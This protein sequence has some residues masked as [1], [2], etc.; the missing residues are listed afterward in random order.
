MCCLR[1]I[2]RSTRRAKC[3]S[4]VAL[5]ARLPFGQS[6]HVWVVIDLPIGAVVYGRHTFGRVSKRD[7]FIRQLAHWNEEP[8]E[9]R[10][11]LT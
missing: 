11:C 9:C 8:G 5:A 2:E 10:R 7:P 4:L 1:S 6:S 3:S